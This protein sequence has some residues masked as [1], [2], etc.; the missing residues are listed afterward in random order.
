VKGW[1]E[2]VGVFTDP[3][4]MLWLVGSTLIEIDDE[5]QVER[6]YFSQESMQR[7][8]QFEGGRSGGR[9]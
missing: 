3:K 6:R 2:V 4:A 8:V 7:Y 9:A 1:I 5:W